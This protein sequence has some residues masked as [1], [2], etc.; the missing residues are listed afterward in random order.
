MRVWILSSRL[1][2]AGVAAV[3]AAA[4]RVAAMVV[5]AALLGAGAAA[6][7]PAPPQRTASPPD[8][9]REQAEKAL[10]SGQV[11]RAGQMVTAYLKQHPADGP[12]HLLL[13]RV[14]LE[15]ADLE[16]AYTELRRALAANPRDVDALYYQ[17]IVTARLAGRQFQRLEEIAPDSPRLH[18]LLAESLEAQ[19]RRESA[20][21]EYARALAARPD[22]LEPLLALGKLKRIR[23]ACDEAIALYRRAE[24]VR[25]TFEGAYGLAVCQ[26]VLQD[27]AAAAAQ[28]EV[29][30]Q[31]EPQAAIAWVGLAKSLLALGR[32]AEAVARLQKAVA[33]EPGMGEAWYALGQA[34]QAAG[35]RTAAADAFRKAG[36]LRPPE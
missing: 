1:A 5:A 22:L 31:R 8:G 19:D 11:E 12:A 20:E 15:E 30:I 27:H 28:F 7:G 33:L 10:S 14:H 3:L 9:M 21:A 25:P 18:Q 26:A 13:A 16:S 29:A 34:Y 23:L 32:P 4:R 35:D 6:A 17:G 2:R 36:E 24:A